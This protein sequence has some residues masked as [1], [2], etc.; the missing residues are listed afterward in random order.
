MNLKIAIA[1]NNNIENKME[2]ELPEDMITLHPIEQMVSDFVSDRL[3]IAGYP[4][5]NK[6]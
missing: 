6:D 4:K 2:L 1:I 5:R 3:I